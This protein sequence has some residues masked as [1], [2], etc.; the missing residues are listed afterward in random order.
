MCPRHRISVPATNR[1]GAGTRVNVLSSWP[2]KH[3]HRRRHPNA[4]E[5]YEAGYELR[6]WWRKSRQLDGWPESSGRC[7]R[8]N[9]EQRRGPLVVFIRPESSS[10]RRRELMLR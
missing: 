10:R 1:D 8:Q 7:G 2:A 9:R 6:V 5:E 4:D 3:Y